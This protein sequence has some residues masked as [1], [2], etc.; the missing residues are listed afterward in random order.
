MSTFP[1]PS[2]SYEYTNSYPAPFD[3]AWIWPPKNV[4]PTTNVWESITSGAGRNDKLLLSLRA[5]IPPCRYESISENEFDK[6]KEWYSK[7][8]T[9]TKIDSAIGASLTASIYIVIS[10]FSVHKGSDS[11]SSQTWYKKVA[12]LS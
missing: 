11:S 5:T 6:S 2:V 8:S 10:L 3:W 7:F 1:V 12:V 4:V 9:S